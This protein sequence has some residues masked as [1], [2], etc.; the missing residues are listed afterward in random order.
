MNYQITMWRPDGPDQNRTIDWLYGPICNAMRIADVIRSMA[1][2]NS[3]YVAVP[4]SIAYLEALPK[5]APRY[6][7]TI[8]D[9]I[10]DD[11]LY[12]LPKF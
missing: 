7:R 8:P 10:W 3:F 11:N 5:G 6:V 12:A 1:Q 2:G 4:G 9:G